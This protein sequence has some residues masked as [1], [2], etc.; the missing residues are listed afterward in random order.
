MILTFT[1][2]PK[3]LSNREKQTETLK[4][5]TNPTPSFSGVIKPTTSRPSVLKPTCSK[6]FKQSTNSCEAAGS[7]AAYLAMR[8]R[9]KQ[10]V[11]APLTME[12]LTDRLEQEWIAQEDEAGTGIYINNNVSLSVHCTALLSVSFFYSHF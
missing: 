1:P 12:N 9:Q 3:K 7:V 5:L 2:T 6:L 10:N 4:K 11:E 8:K